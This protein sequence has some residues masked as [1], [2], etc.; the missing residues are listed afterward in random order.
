VFAVQAPNLW[1]LFHQATPGLCDIFN[2][3]RLLLDTPYAAH[4]IEHGYGTLPTLNF[5]VAVCEPLVARLRV[6]PVPDV[7]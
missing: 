1:Q 5:S 7:G 2:R 4:F 3:V 6:L